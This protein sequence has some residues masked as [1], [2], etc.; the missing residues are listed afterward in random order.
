MRRPATLALLLITLS[1]CFSTNAVR[2][3]YLQRRASVAPRTAHPVV[4]VPGFG[5]SRLYDPQLGR[6]V[7]GTGRAM[8]TRRFPDEFDLPFD[9]VQERYVADRLVPSGFVGSRGPINPAWHLCDALHRFGGYDRCVEEPRGAG[10]RNAYAFAWDWR[11]SHRE[12]AERLARF[13]D[14]VRAEHGDPRL[15]V[16]VVTHSAG[17]LVATS[18]AAAERD[19][20]APRLRRLILLAP[21][22]RG[23]LESFR[24]LNDTE[25]FARRSLTPAMSS[26]FASLPEL[27]PLDGRIFVDEQGRSMPDDI[28]QL[29]T[30]KRHRLGPFAAQISAEEERRF[31]RNLELGHRFRADFEAVRPQLNVTTIAGGC[32][33]TAR[34]ALLRSDGTLAFYPQQ[35]RENEQLLRG[36]LYEDGDGSVTLSSARSDSTSVVCDGHQGIA[37][38]PTVYL[39]LL[40][41]LEEPDGG[42]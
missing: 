35:L 6:F 18:L 15:S 38:D 41:A 17:A 8:L 4:V 7:W 37:L 30:W 23:T 42:R 34:R 9:E 31:A 28:W 2:E 12:N 36:V 11:L 16:D 20:R 21:P 25:K 29:E 5:H 39:L 32:V 22:L 33:P 14:D 24:L 1:A 19:S 27:F 40:R 13:V 10:A 26:T 3:D